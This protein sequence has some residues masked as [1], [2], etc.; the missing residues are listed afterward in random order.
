MAD[1]P[2]MIE[3]TAAAARGTDRGQPIAE[4]VVA[5][6]RAARIILPGAAVIERIAI[7]GRT[8]ACKRA[9]DALMAELS[10]EHLTQTG[11]AARF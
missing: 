9:A 6:L 10:A 1:L 3:V 8:R 4:A 5:A 2:W 7:A 11:Q